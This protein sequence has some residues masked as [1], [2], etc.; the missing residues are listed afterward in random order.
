M[1]DTLIIVNT[2][3]IEFAKYCTGE[4][5]P[6]ALSLGLFTSDTTIALT[7]V[8]GDLTIMTGSDNSAYAEKT[9]AAGDW[10]TPTIV[11]AKA[12]NTHAI[13][14]W[15]FATYAAATV[16]GYYVATVADVLLWAC[17]FETSKTVQYAGETISVTPTFKFGPA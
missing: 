1:A 12:Q 16:F 13:Q 11:S 7:T 6:G 17:D 8:Y 4:T 5:N 9:L 2:G 10:T 3:L 14:T 15:T